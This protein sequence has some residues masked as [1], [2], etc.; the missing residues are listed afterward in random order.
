MPLRIEFYEKYPLGGKGDEYWVDILPA[1]AKLPESEYGYRRT[2]PLIE[3]IERPIEIPNNKKECII[4][5]W[6]GDDMVIL[7][8]YDDLCLQLHDIEE[9]MLIE[10]EIIRASVET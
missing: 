4:R 1:G 6:G 10:S 7:K 5:F 3:T 9:Q 8:N 2:M